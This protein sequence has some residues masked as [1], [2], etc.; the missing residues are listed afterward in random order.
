MK[1]TNDYV[2]FFM[3]SMKLKEKVRDGARLTKRYDKPQTPYQRVLD[4]AQVSSTAKR[5]LRRRYAALNPA[6]L[7]RQINALQKT[8]ATLTGRRRD[9]TAGPPKPAANHPWRRSA[10][11]RKAG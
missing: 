8:L 6:A 1:I 5:H 4:S 2:N 10:T 11:K 7:K 9:A 3:P